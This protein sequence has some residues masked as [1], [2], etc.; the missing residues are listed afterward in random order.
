MR[1][2]IESRLCLLVEGLT[3]SPNGTVGAA[4][5]TGH[6]AHAPATLEQRD[7]H[8]AS[9]FKLLFGACWSHRD[10]IGKLTLGL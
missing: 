5:V 3:P 7:G 6:L 10:L 9:D 1:F 4:D 2:C 8:A